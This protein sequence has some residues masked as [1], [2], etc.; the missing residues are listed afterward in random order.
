MLCLH[1]LKLDRSESMRKD[2]DCGMAYPMYPQG[3]N[4]LP[5][6]PPMP[7]MMGNQMMFDNSIES[8]ISNIK[9]VKCLQK[10]LLTI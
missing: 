1:I 4:M 5:G 6:I 7:N 9:L 10:K 2:R 8:R 3:I